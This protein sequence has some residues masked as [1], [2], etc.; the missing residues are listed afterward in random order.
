M[1]RRRPYS[2][3]LITTERT[4][5][6]ALLS[7][8]CREREMRS[9]Q[10]NVRSHRWRRRARQPSCLSLDAHSWARSSSSVW[11]SQRP[12][13]RPHHDITSP[14]AVMPAGIAAGFGALPQRPSVTRWSSASNGASPQAPRTTC[15]PRTATPDRPDSL[16]GTRTLGLRMTCS[17]M[18]P[19]PCRPR[20]LSRRLCWFG[21]STTAAPDNGHPLTD[22]DR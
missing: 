19:R 10:V 20:R 5:T 3:L 22:V 12:E 1:I 13:Q 8:P 9:G 4:P 16:S 7:V 21:R 15:T 11:G 6:T 14:D 18:R 17:T 2:Q